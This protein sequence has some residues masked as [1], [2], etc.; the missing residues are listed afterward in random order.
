MQ[1][2][3]ETYMEHLKASY[4]ERCTVDSMLQRFNDTMACSDGIKYM[5]VSV[6]GR[7]HSF[8]VRADGPKFK[9]GDILKAAGWKTPA[10]NFKRGSVM[11]DSYKDISWIGF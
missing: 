8:I 4:A 3:I 5:R 11:D 6:D 1:Q 10:L 9:A 7:V 2:Q